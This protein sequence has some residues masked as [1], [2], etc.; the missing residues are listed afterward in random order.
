MLKTK[1]RL[2]IVVTSLA[3]LFYVTLLQADALTGFK[4]LGQLENPEILLDS[5][6]HAASP[7][8]FEFKEGGDPAFLLMLATPKSIKTVTLYWCKGTE[9]AS[10]SVELS[11]DLFTWKKGFDTVSVFA[12]AETGG[13]TKAEISLRSSTASFVRIVLKQGA[14]KKVKV[15]GLVV[16]LGEMFPLKI[17]RIT[18]LT[19]KENSISFKFLTD[20]EAVGMIRFGP[21][22]NILQDGPMIIDYGKEHEVTIDRLLKGTKYVFVGIGQ[23]GSGGVKYSL[24]IE[25]K[26]AGIPLPL[27]KS[28]NRSLCGADKFRLDV[29]CNVDTRMDIEYGTDPAKLIKK[30]FKV[31]TDTHHFDF[32]GLEPEKMFYFR[33]TATDKFGNTIVS[34]LEQILME[35]ENIVSTSVVSGDFNYIGENLGPVFETNRE[36]RLWDKDFSYMSG[37]LMSGNIFSSKQQIRFDFNK[38]VNVSRIDLIWW[39]LIYS[40]ASTVMI[41]S[42]GKNW[43]TIAEN[44]APDTSI[45]YPMAGSSSHVVTRVPINKNVQAIKCEF[46]Q[47]Q[48]YRRFSQYQ[49]IRLLEVFI[50]PQKNLISNIVINEIEINNKKTIKK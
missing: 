24:P 31:M 14:A 46:A 38:A 28:I 30:Q 7:A 49:N 13:L 16:Q 29:G 40:T 34:A 15:A 39:G 3:L 47:G 17:V 50:V 36:S 21:D 48:T 2:T 32:M 4:I 22:K 35:P 18:P 10:V 41:T 19:I 9:P 11:D 44:V 6:I 8:I 5:Q 27:I 1:N 12:P 33:L 42:D 25:V 45:S 43:M 20:V 26:T 37:S 23:D